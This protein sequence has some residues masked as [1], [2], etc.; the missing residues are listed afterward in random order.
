MT[1]ESLITH[2]RPE[3]ESLDPR[4]S[5]ATLEAILSEPLP[6]RAPTRPRR[7]AVATGVVASSVVLGLGGVAWATGNLPG[8]DNDAPRSVHAEV[9][10]WGGTQLADGLHAVVDVTLPDGTGFI[11][12]QA[13]GD[14]S[15]EAVSHVPAGEPHNRM[16]NGST[17]C[18]TDAVPGG[19]RVSV[20]REDAAAPGDARWQTA[21]WYPVAYGVAEAPAAQVRVHGILAWTGDRID[22]TIPVDPETGGFA[23]ALAVTW[24]AGNFPTGPT[25]ALSGLTLD[26]LDANGRLLASE[27]DCEGTA[28]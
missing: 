7:T 21:R 16:W 28:R 26:Y 12:W 14:S 8:L 22:M 4:W 24:P 25:E 3:A 11:V 5:V 23:D 1:P 27:C 9:A 13:A 6:T 18:G 10:R 17:A 2:L 15:C 20:V 19:S